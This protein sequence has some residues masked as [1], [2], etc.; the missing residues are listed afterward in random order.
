M[1]KYQKKMKVVEYKGDEHTTRWC[2]TWNGP[3]EYGKET[4]W[5]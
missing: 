2:S 5:T 3:Q 1:E 4:G